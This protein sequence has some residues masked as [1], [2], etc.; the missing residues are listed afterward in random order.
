MKDFRFTNKQR[1]SSFSA[2]SSGQ[3]TRS[4]SSSSS[5]SG[6]ASQQAFVNLDAAN[7]NYPYNLNVNT[8]A[9][10]LNGTVTVNG[11]A[12][13]QLNSNRSHLNLSPYLSIG[14]NVIEISAQYSPNSSEI[15]VRLSGV[16]T[17]VVQQSRGSGVLNC[18]LTILVV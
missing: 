13:A 7:I 1:T 3:Y 4:S 12:V 9:A 15:E 14:T 6:T 10:S 17:N 2:V 11:K 5:S 16:D 8:S 18:T